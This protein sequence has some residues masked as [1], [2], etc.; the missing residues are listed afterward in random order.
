MSS[1]TVDKLERKFG[2]TTGL[3]SCLTLSTITKR[4]VELFKQTGGGENSISGKT[5]E[6]ECLILGFD[7]VNKMVKSFPKNVYFFTANQRSANV[8]GSTLNLHN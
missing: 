5:I 8:F 3:G 1:Y 2:N 6:N 7:S 4:D